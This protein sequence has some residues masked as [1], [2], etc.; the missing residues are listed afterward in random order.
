MFQKKIV[1]TIPQKVQRILIV[2][3]DAVP[4][5]ATFFRLGKNKQS[6]LGIPL[7]D[8]VE[9]HEKLMYYTKTIDSSFIEPIPVMDESLIQAGFNICY[10]DE[11]GK[12][13]GKSKNTT[14]GLLC[15]ASLVGRA[16][17]VKESTVEEAD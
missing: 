6:F 15:G 10:V 3:D 17:L 4:K 8:V 9:E 13:N 1:K 16:L 5:G 12:L 14:A 7:Y 2:E 11:E